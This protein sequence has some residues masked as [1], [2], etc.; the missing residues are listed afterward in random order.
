MPKYEPPWRERAAQLILAILQAHPTAS[1]RDLKSLFRQLY[2]WG[3]RKRWPYKAWRAEVR[4]LCPRAGRR[5]RAA[6]LG[7]DVLPLE[8]WE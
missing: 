5:R 7:P 3:E 6:P 8:G 1:E 4:A 2:P